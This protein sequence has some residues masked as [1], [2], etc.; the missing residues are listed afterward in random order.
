MQL[1]RKMWIRLLAASGCAW[2]CSLAHAAPPSEWIAVDESQL[3]EMRGGFTGDNGL[4]ISFGVE[5]SVSINGEVLSAARFNVNDAGKLHGQL[6][7]IT[8]QGAT[9]LIQNGAGNMFQPGQLSSAAAATFVQ[10]SLNDQTIRSTTVVNAATNSLEFLKG[11][12]LQSA[13]GQA[14]SNVA[15][16]R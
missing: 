14:L 11:I 16:V 1:S 2:T 8:A 9:T 10:N 5:R 12:N 4:R 15:A 13:L 6:P 7:T 3:A